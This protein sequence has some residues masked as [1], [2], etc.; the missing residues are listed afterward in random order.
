MAMKVA[1]TPRCRRCW[2]PTHPPPVGVLR[3]RTARG[4]CCLSCPDRPDSGR[5]AIPLF[6]ADGCGVHDHRAPVAASRLSLQLALCAQRPCGEPTTGSTKAP[7]GRR[8]HP[9]Q[10]QAAVGRRRAG[11]ARSSRPFRK[12]PNSSSH[13]PTRVQPVKRRCAV[14]PVT[15][16]SPGNCRQAHPLVST[17][18][19]AV[20][21]S[22]SSSDAVP[23]PADEA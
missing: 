20:N 10:P 4:I 1:G 21:T 6:R 17:Y 15:P 11:S 7:N 16:N 3:P 18:T 22:R 9:P 8:A 14:E 19:I 12:H 2:R 23:R 5:S 13:S